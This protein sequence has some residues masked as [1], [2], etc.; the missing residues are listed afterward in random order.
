MCLICNVVGVKEINR[1]PGEPKLK[2]WIDDEENE[3]RQSIQNR[4]KKNITYYLGNAIKFASIRKAAEAL[5]IR[6]YKDKKQ[7]FVPEVFLTKDPSLIYH[8]K[9]ELEKLLA[10]RK[11][12]DAM[13]M[14]W[15][16]KM[17]TIEG[18]TKK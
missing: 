11:A 3:S 9:Q 1:R 2:D 18:A 14:K 10:A 7:I 4:I 16:C 8:E 13:K 17:K 5:F 12:D 6:D 15:R